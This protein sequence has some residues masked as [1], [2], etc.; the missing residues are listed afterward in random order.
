MNI[1][2]FLIASAAV[3]SIVRFLILPSLRRKIRDDR[4]PRL[5]RRIAMVEVFKFIAF[6]SMVAAMSSA[7]AVVAIVLASSRF[8][9]AEALLR[10]ARHVREAIEMIS[11]DLNA[12]IILVLLPTLLFIIYRSSKKT[13]GARYRK[14]LEA[15]V[16]RLVALREVGSLPELPPTP[17]MRKVAARIAA[18]DN[19]IA[20]RSPYRGPDIPKMKELR[21]ELV[22]AH[23]LLDLDRRA[24]VQFDTS[25]LDVAPKGRFGPLATFFM[26]QGMLTSLEASSRTLSFV[27]IFLLMP[28]L[29]GVSMSGARTPLDV[30]IAQLQIAASSKAA[31]KSFES[32]KADDDRTIDDQVA[33]QQ[34]AAAY[35]AAWQSRG[36]WQ[37]VTRE[38][39]ASTEMLRKLRANEVRRNILTEF[40]AQTGIEVM[41]DAGESARAIASRAIAMP[42]APLNPI[43]ERMAARL[44]TVKRKQPHAFDKIKH[45][46]RDFKASFGRIAEKRDVES[47]LFSAIFERALDHAWHPDHA[48]GELAEEL[49]TDVTPELV[50]AADESYGLNFLN[51]LA[52]GESLDQAAEQVKPTPSMPIH[53]AAILQERGVVAVAEKERKGLIASSDQGPALFSDRTRL[54]N[55]SANR[56]LDVIQGEDEASTADNVLG[57]VSSY[58]DHFPGT[59]AG[60]GNTDRSQFLKF[61]DP[62]LKDEI[63]DARSFTHLR[64]SPHV[65]GVL[66]GVAPTTPRSPLAF[67]DLEWKESGDSVTLTLV[68]ANNRRFDLGPWRKQIVAQ[69]LAYAADGRPT[70]VT[71]LNVTRARA[72]RVLVHPALV[73]SPL[74]CRTIEIDKLVF[75][76]FKLAQTNMKTVE[77][78][79]DLYELASAII[80][81]RLAPANVIDPAD[82]ML[83]ALLT[84]IP[85]LKENLANAPLATDLQSMFDP[86]RSPI[87]VKDEYFDRPIVDVIRRCANQTK[88]DAYSGC[89]EHSPLG[90]ITIKDAESIPVL[91]FVSGVRE[92]PYSPD[93]DLAFLREP[94]SNPL[95]P[96]DFDMQVVFD[97]PP[98]FGSRSHEK[99]EDPN[100]W[101]FP[102]LHDLINQTIETLAKNNGYECSVIRDLRE[103]T[104]AQRLFRTILSGA[105]GPSFPIEK[106]AALEHDTV[107]SLPS[108]SVST[109]KWISVAKDAPPE[110]AKLRGALG[111]VEGT[112]LDACGAI[113]GQTTIQA[114]CRQ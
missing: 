16:K 77:E 72:Q 95:W 2:T 70:A 51:A 50:K 23:A 84:E 102:S 111:V 28:S 56:L 93:A 85:T 108:A 100:P 87:T 81:R 36:A 88:I 52:N 31:E 49:T 5:V 21:H 79:D 3:T 103:F 71:V 105:F 26:S 14:A 43:G 97:S 62:A 64:G 92:L 68:A 27:G 19:A 61:R 38:P 59:A 63:A 53:P 114:A 18:L 113:P 54:N 13:V 37:N 39:E 48:V 34:I 24:Q 112:G 90:A 74:G 83:N 89:I 75:D 44:N 109:P 58:E 35:Q 82:K 25:F 78:Q 66:I 110:V 107:S 1:Y 47:V 45:T 29:I 96:L 4:T 73:N 15:E 80:V 86:R 30:R 20:E 8:E 7:I 94:S 9:S 65:G 67:R 17:E 41:S 91:N 40:S 76:H 101:T 42:D 32:A 6:A 22:K 57:S 12:V 60:V 33:I 55:F 11:T 46:L 98:P 69:A 10:Q 104:I 106:L 99:V